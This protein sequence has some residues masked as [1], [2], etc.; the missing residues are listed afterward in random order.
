M[1]FPSLRLP[2]QLLLAALLANL[3]GNAAAIGL[4]EPEI[5][6]TIGERLQAHI[7]LTGIDHTSP[8]A[9][10]TSDCFSVTATGSDGAR[11]DTR[12]RLTD[13]R[14]QSWLEISSRQVLNEPVLTLLV[15]IACDIG[16]QREYTVLPD[17]PVDRSMRPAIVSG[18]KQS[19]HE[20]QNPPPPPAPR[21]KPRLA[22]PAG[23]RLMLSTTLVNLPASA[24]A[25]PD[26]LPA[27]VDRMLRLETE[28]RYLDSSLVALDEAIR[29]GQEKAAIRNQLKLAESLQA[30]SL[31]TAAKT[32]AGA[33]PN[34]SLAQWLQ[35]AASTL[36]GGLFGAGLMQLA[37]HRRRKANRDE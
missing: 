26:P 16:L 6:S 19:P 3:A 13:R 35:M 11:L 28:L 12:L 34:D 5:R 33:A 37:D 23:D 29:L 9:I 10:P 1:K 27:M 17:F 4:G 18:E 15:T 22:P 8:S 25:Q 30:E 2:I 7:E 31:A 36:I 24:N 32:P 21:R 14:G 20:W